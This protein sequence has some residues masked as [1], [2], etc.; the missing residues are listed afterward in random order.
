MKSI[1]KKTLL[2]A[3]P[4]LFMFS[5]AIAQGPPPPPGDHGSDDDRPVEPAPIGSGLAILMAMGAAYGAKKVYDARK[6][7][8]E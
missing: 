4:F 6:Q 3:L 8:R 5:A 2:A 7:L 1:F